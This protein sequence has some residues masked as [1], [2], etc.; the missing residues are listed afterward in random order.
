MHWDPRRTTGYPPP[1][2]GRPALPKRSYT[3][4]IARLAAWLID[5][6]PLVVGAVIWDA[7]A[8]GTAGIDCVTYDHGGV[9]C[10]S[11]AS[12]VGNIVFGLVVLISVSYAVWNHGYRQGT[13]GSSIGKSVLGFKVV[14]E[15]T[16]Q[17]VGFGKSMVRQLA[18]IVD[19]VI[20][21]VGYLFP[22][23]DA[24]RQTLADKVMTTVCVPR[25]PRPQ[26]QAP[27]PARY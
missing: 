20:C 1:Q 26:P 27:Y 7:V 13:T 21:F 17:P 11:T 8:I 2:L 10:T 15:K 18:H 19:A 23:W 22:L 14:S 9:A 25:N 12:E 24:R 5:V 16:W 3:P 4:W 6:F